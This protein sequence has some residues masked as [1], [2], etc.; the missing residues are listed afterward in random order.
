MNTKNLK[1][2]VLGG[3]IVVLAVVFISENPLT[4]G[5]CK[6]VAMW[7]NGVKYCVDNNILPEYIRQIA[8]FLSFSVILLSLLTYWAKDEVFRAWW[9]FAKWWV[10]VIV[11]VTLF[12]E[13]V[14]SRGGGWGISSGLDEFVILWLLY[15]IFILTS[16]IKI[17]R[18]YW[19]T[20]SGK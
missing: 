6:N 5:F 17:V 13:Y 8:G 10:P 11:V 12:F 15:I 14:G 7:G 4:F 2:V 9:N 1:R 20:R 19:K 3:S 16:L 18:A